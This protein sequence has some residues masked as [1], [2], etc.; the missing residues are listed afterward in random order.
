[1]L[2]HYW[3]NHWLET[4]AAASLK[5]LTHA[6]PAAQ[7]YPRANWRQGDEPQSE[8][9][10]FA[11]RFQSENRA[12]TGGTRPGDPPGPPTGRPRLGSGGWGRRRRAQR[13]EQRPG[14]AGSS[15]G[16]STAQTMGAF[17][18]FP[19]A[20]PPAVGAKPRRRLRTGRG[21]GTT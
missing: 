18:A 4:S 14:E 21:P 9:G 13:A 1:M 10:C 12:G 8:T 6:H 15:R 20:T 2:R 7:G 11:P 3:T 17:P 5:T 16:P 19:A